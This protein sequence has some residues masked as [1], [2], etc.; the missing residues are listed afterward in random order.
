MVMSRTDPNEDARL[1]AE[2]VAGSEG[3]L[4]ALYD[5]HAGAV[6]AVACRL[7]TDRQIA[8]DVVQE[9]FLTLWN[10]A[11]QFDPGLGS[12]AAW[13]LTIG[14]NRTIDRLRAAG[15]RPTILSI[16]AT[17][18][19]DETDVATLERVARMGEVVGA[20][21]LG[22]GPELEFAGRETREALGAAL[23][24][25]TDP[26]RQVLVLAYRDELTQTEIAERLGLPLGTVKTRTRRGLLHLRGILGPEY[27]PV[28][29][30]MPETETGSVGTVGTGVTGV[31]A[32]DPSA[33]IGAGR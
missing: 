8:E 28:P 18:Q 32:G 7:T 33:R 21:D 20:A 24:E 19:G 15:R 31:P 25:M 17:R 30:A 10:R 12:L 1:V 26:E 3:A 4:E 27:A 6:Y 9:T 16:S 2:M 11:E 13:L 23:A 29:V 5:R 14:R 22:P